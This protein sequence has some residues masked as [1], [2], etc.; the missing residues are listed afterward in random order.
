META[1]RRN[2]LLRS[3]RHAH[4]GLREDR[5]GRRFNPLLLWLGILGGPIAFGLDRLA[6]AV[7]LSGRCV[8]T[9]GD[10]ILFGLTPEQEIMAAITILC[11]LSAAAAG[12][13]CWHIWRRTRWSS[14]ERSGESLLAIPFWALGG[15]FISGV[16]FVATVLT[17]GLAIGL[18]A[19]CAS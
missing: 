9:A 8:R 10:T 3:R 15:V 1:P 17:G 19:T 12:V 6:G 14:E 4:P 7:L 16:F 2:Q 5:P 13:L 11:A 18:S